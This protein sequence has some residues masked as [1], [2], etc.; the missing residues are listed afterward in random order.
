[1]SQDWSILIDEKPDGRCRVHDVVTGKAWWCADYEACLAI[2]RRLHTERG[3][4]FGALTEK[5]KRTR[6]SRK[7]KED[8]TPWMNIELGL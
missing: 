4:G 6:S 2:V 7:V 3:P 8:P 5:P 1:M